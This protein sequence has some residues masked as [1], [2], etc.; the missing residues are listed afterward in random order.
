MVAV[1]AAGHAGTFGKREAHQR[2]T[3]ERPR[4]GYPRQE[5]VARAPSPT[6][7]VKGWLGWVR[8]WMEGGEGGGGRRLRAQ[9]SV[10]E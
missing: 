9:G 8:M 3:S 4:S 5:V 6:C 2:Q 1:T 10:R 7:Q